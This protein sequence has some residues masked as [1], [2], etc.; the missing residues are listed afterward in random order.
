M[1]FARKNDRIE[2]DV[3]VGYARDECGRLL[4]RIRPTGGTVLHV[5]SARGEAWV[6]FDDSVVER[7]V[8]L[9]KL[10]PGKP[11]KGCKR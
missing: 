2:M 10:R 11:Y 3:H 7:R 9:D 5:D 4:H 6:L 1:I 8:S